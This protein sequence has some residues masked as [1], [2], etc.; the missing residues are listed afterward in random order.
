[1]KNENE[2]N[3]LLLIQE[4]NLHLHLTAGY[5]S[6]QDLVSSQKSDYVYYRRGI[7]SDK[8]VENRRLDGKA[9]IK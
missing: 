3:A 4:W 8:K 2:N 7:E 9:F 1:M 5:D 6:N